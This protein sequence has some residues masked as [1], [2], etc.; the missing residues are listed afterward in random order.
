MYEDNFPVPCSAPE[1]RQFDFWLGEWDL[2]WG[3]DG[4]GKNIINSIYDGCVIQENFDGQPGMNLKGMS[5]SLYDPKLGKWKQTWVD[6][7]G[8][9]F[10]LLGEFED[11]VMT[12]VCE[13][14]MEGKPILLRMAFHNISENELDWNWERSDDDGENW[15]LRW[16]I[17]YK[18]KGSE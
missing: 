3:E 15:K 10:D 16:H 18:R 8:G 17:H 2:T 12:L 13:K 7:S 6:N 5:V 1:A 14:E 4:R 9:Y 11:G